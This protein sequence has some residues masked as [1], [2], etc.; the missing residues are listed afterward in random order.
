LAPAASGDVAR[1]K[2]SVECEEVRMATYVFSDVHGHAA[3]L[4]RA[5]E[6][7]APAD[8]D[9]FYCLGDMIDRGPDPLGVISIVRSLPNVHVLMGNHE[10]LMMACML[11]PEGE[12]DAI[13]AANWGINGG[14]VTSEALAGL[15]EDEAD[16]IVA[17]VASL[18]RCAHVTVGERPYL[19]VHA[20]IDPSAVT[21]EGPWD[22]RRLDALLAEQSPDDLLWIREGF[23]G[24]H[25]GLVD[26]EGKGPIVIAGHT[27]TPYL[28]RLCADLDEPLRDEDGRAKMLKVGAD[29]TTGGVADRWDIDAGA[30]GGAGFGRV[31]IM[32]LDDGAEFYEDISED[33]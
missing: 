11:E 31:G 1:L 20:G 13:N 10:D 28:D 15:S 29:Q 22:D 8:D 12:L 7:I 21:V 5:I 14:I 27:P 17:W 18:P 6:K 32:R 3:P 4:A 9:V 19:L 24:S 23:W 16:E 26:A 25:T 30:A 33:E 2:S